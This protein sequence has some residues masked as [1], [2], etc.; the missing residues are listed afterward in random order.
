VKRWIGSPTAYVNVVCSTP[1]GAPADA[2]FT[3]TWADKTSLLGTGPGA[4]RGYVWGSDDTLPSYTP[5]TTYSYNDARALNTITRL[6]IGQ[7]VVRFS[8]LF[9]TAGTAGGDVQVTAYGGNARCDTSSS[10]NSNY[11]S[12]DVTVHCYLPNGA[13]T[14]SLFTAQFQA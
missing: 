14:D 13:L 6:G 7:Y 1:G 3:L 8:E 4:P 11:R 2:S 9:S 5:A 12:V 10:A